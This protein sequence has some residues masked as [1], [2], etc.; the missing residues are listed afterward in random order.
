MIY[1]TKYRGCQ[2]G[3]RSVGLHPDVA[4]D[5]AAMLRAAVAMC[6]AQQPRRKPTTKGEIH[7]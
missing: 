2:A 3:E 4:N 1:L 6:S 7:A 5:I